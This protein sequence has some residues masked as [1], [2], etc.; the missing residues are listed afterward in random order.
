MTFR[1]A[2]AVAVPVKSRRIKLG[3]VLLTGLLA[4]S[5]AVAA[6]TW[7]ASPEIPDE[8][9]TPAPR[10]GDGAS[11]S[12][13]DAPALW[14]PESPPAGRA[15]WL[16]FVEARA[17]TIRGA[18]GRLTPARQVV[19]EGFAYDAEAVAWQERTQVIVL[20]DRGG[21]I[22]VATVVDGQAR[23]ADPPCDLDPC[24]D[25]STFE[26]RDRRLVYGGGSD[27]LLRHALQGTSAS[28]DGGLRLLGACNL[29]GLVEIPD[30][31]YRAQAI[32]EPLDGVE[33][34]RFDAVGDG[35][36][37]SAWL[38]P[39]IPYP[40]G[41]LAEG[42]EG[43]FEVRLA[44]ALAGG[45]VDEAVEFRQ[46]GPVDAPGLH[47]VPL[48]PWGLDETG[49]TATFTPRQAYEQAAGD[50]EWDVLRQWANEHPD[51]VAIETSTTTAWYVPGWWGSYRIE[52]R[53]LTLSDGNAA[54]Y[55]LVG[56]HEPAPG[57]TGTVPSFGVYY[58]YFAEPV[59]VRLPVAARDLPAMPTWASLEERARAFHEAE[60]GVDRGRLWMLRLNCD[61]HCTPADWVVTVGRYDFYWDGLPTPARP[62][63]QEPERAHHTVSFAPDGMALGVRDGWQRQDSGLLLGNSQAT[64]AA[65]AAI[66]VSRE[67]P[68]AAIA[69]GAGVASVVIAL[70]A[71]LT[72]LGLFSRVREDRLLDHP[73]RRQ[74]HELVQQEPGAHFQQLQRATGLANGTLVHH[75]DKL[76]AA[77]LVRRRREGGYTCFYPPGK[78]RAAASPV[79][80]AGARQILATIAGE[81]GI[82][83]RDVARRTGLD[84][85]TVSHHV[86][87]LEATQLVQVD[88]QPG[89]PM[90]LRATP[91]GAAAG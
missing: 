91:A 84:P 48:K 71:K 34:L 25:G 30:L 10:L 7:V 4:A 51:H 85:S 88:R 65:S 52:Y 83:L 5:A 57:P 39:H 3:A 49:S 78:A 54:L 58:E 23:L 20:D 38:A 45:V 50:P 87:R 37:V 29:A 74:L 18:D 70:A 89:G 77:D 66:A 69:V 22:G 33:A 6:W 60:D 16:R 9:G 35:W 62:L 11:F 24:A 2:S 19:V 76:V 75:L 14:T 41:I 46:T 44:E 32:E 15:D 43:R 40:V 12:L 21:R 26:V 67:I 73:R 90:A 81:P 28:L 63:G 42:P 86:K 55:L 31:L 59:E 64:P 68:G 82:S 80:S 61:S 27:C 72:G 53:S 36:A 79:K 1:P 56:R 8:F 17:D 13:L 47:D